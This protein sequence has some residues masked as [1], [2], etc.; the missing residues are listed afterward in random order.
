[1]TSRT[2]KVNNSGDTFSVAEDESILDA[3]LR[4]GLSLPYGC[5]DGACGSCK[6]RVLAGEI[7][8]PDKDLAGITMEEMKSGSAL[9]CQARAKSDLLIEARLQ[10]TAGDIPVRKLPC[11]V[12][13][14]EQLTHDV[15]RLLLKLPASERLQFLPGQYIDI[16]LASGKRRSFSLANAPHDDRYLELHVR[17]YPG[18]LFSELAFHKLKDK[19]LLRLEGP[20]GT[21]CFNEDSP[22]PV[23]MVAGGTGFAPVKSIM[24]HLL[25]AGIDRPVHLYWGVRSRADL[26]LDD[27]PRRWSEQESLIEYHPVLSEPKPDDDW[28]GRTGLVHEAVLKDMQDLSGYDVYTCGPPPMVEAVLN[29]FTE[30]GLPRE[31]IFSDSFEF[32]VD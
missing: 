1:M 9:F 15:M 26:Y 19:A 20:F 30:R 25:A 31:Q 22:R 11:R 23:I 17:Y 14:H 2:V 28:D 21:F 29:T 3:A 10:E 27:L 18:G 24:E 13:Q 7:S 32:A 6:G 16:L 12:E 5:R 4:H 8:Y